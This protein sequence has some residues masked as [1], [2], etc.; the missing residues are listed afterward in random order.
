METERMSTIE[1]QW[2][3]QQAIGTNFIISNGNGAIA[4]T[5]AGV[6]H[7]IALEGSLSLIDRLLLM[8]YYGTIMR[9]EE[10]E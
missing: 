3:L 4:L 6:E 8:M 1:F 10:D 9:G 7:C 5:D 2:A